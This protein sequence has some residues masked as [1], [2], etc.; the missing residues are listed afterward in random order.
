[1]YF[2]LFITNIYFKRRW[3]GISVLAFS[4]L[5]RSRRVRVILAQHPSL[6]KLTCLQHRLRLFISTLIFIHGAQVVHVI[7][8]QHSTLIS[9]TLS[10]KR[11]CTRVL[12]LRV[13]IEQLDCVG[14]LNPFN[15]YF[16]SF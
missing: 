1:M 3:D 2:N 4:H 11:F 7:F 5:S 13:N 16:N 10:I 14:L 15:I 8:A 6:A 9:K 12:S